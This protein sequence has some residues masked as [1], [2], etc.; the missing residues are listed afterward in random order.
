MNAYGGLPP[1]D[2]TLWLVTVI[3]NDE[4]YGYVNGGG[5]LTEGLHTITAFPRENYIFL[6]WSDGNTDNP[7]IVNIVSDTVF[8]ATF[9]TLDY[10]DCDTVCL[11]PWKAT[12][13]NNMTCWKT[14][15]ADGDGNT[16]F[17]TETVLAA[18]TSAYFSNI[19]NWLI[20]KAIRLDQP[21]TV[22]GGFRT[23]CTGSST[24]DISFLISTTGSEIEDFTTLASQTMSGISNAVLS[25]SLNDYTGQTVR[26]AIRNHNCTSGAISMVLD[27]L[28]IVSSLS[29]IPSAEPLNYSIV[30][31]GLQLTIS[32]IEGHAIEIFDITG[33]LIAK[34]SDANGTFTMPSTGVYIVHIDGAMPKK[35]VLLK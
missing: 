12:I 17:T 3:S 22:R 19:D 32:G 20:T 4:S 14:I 35:V 11:F 5:V 6:E 33:R 25:A 28:S 30:T 24:Q 13:D 23:I 8:T 26:I 1:T 15:D 21:L 18:S 34:R 29:A 16:W 31:R 27:S 9:N 10:E 2:S 7:R